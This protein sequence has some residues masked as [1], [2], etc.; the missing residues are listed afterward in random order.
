MVLD[1]PYL[2]PSFFPA[3]ALYR[4]FKHL[5]RFHEARESRIVR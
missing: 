4:V 1:I 5:P 3:L 2:D